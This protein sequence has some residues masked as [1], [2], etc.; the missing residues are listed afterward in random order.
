MRR[1]FKSR[2]YRCFRFAGSS[3]TVHKRCQLIMCTL[4]LLL[5]LF[6]QIKSE[7]GAIDILVRIEQCFTISPLKNLI[8]RFTRLSG[9]SMLSVGSHLHRS[10]SNI[11]SFWEQPDS[12]IIRRALD[13]L[14]SPHIL[15]TFPR[16]TMPRSLSR[17][18][19]R[20]LSRS[21]HNPSLAV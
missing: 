1:H 14:D 7:F 11:R 15:H 16:S 20:L 6:F 10:G 8:F 21:R 19:T 12:L 13:R 5:T 2:E 4:F 9:E 18:P 3:S 17:P